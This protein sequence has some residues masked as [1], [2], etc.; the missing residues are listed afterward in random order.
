MPAICTVA[1]SL[2]LTRNARPCRTPLPSP[3]ME[4]LI[5]QCNN[6]YFVDERLPARSHHC[7]CV[8]RNT[9]DGRS[10][11]FCESSKVR[12][13]LPP[14][15]SEIKRATQPSWSELGRRLGLFKRTLLLCFLLALRL[16]MSVGKFPPEKAVTYLYDGD[17]ESPESEKSLESR[18]SSSK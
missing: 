4:F 13:R 15:P 16:P 18:P 12:D 14:S 8:Q 3:G 7:S 10:R 1:S 5:K 9:T 11:W 6:I 17:E 2:E